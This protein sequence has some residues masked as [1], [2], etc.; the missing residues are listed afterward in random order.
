MGPPLLDY[1][2]SVVLVIQTHAI[3]GFFLV[4]VAAAV[5]ADNC[6][7]RSVNFPATADFLV[8]E[9]VADNFSRNTV[10][11]RPETR[12]AKYRQ[13]GRLCCDPGS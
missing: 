1:R 6:G 2:N 12:C 5:A 13:S 4:S 9:R 8:V 7:R 3:I 10:T 11:S